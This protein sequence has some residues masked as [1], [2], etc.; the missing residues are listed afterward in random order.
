MKNKTFDEILTDNGITH[1]TGKQHDDLMAQLGNY[2]TSS[3]TPL[4]KQEITEVSDE[5]IEGILMEGILM[6]YKNEM[7]NLN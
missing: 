4:K 3:A 2:F 6:D 1:L 7:I 5:F